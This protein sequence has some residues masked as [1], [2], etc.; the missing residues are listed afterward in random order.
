MIKKHCLVLFLC[1]SF[2]KKS[3]AKK[4]NNHGDLLFNTYDLIA[5]SNNGTEILVSLIPLNKIQNTRQGLKNIEVSK[6]VLLQSGLTVDLNLDGR[7]FY[8]SVHQLFKFSH[9]VI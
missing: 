3:Y 5:T 6:R 9:K 7:S 1:P 8:T 2:F 4:Y